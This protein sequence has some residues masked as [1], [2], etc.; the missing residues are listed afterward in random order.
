MPMNITAVYAE[1][2]PHFA[3]KDFIPKIM[4]KM[5]S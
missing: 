3:L 1:L 5:K 4:Q 2:F